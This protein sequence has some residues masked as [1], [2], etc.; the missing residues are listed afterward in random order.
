VAFVHQLMD[1]PAGHA[2]WSNVAIPNGLNIVMNELVA[3]VGLFLRLIS[4][5][6]LV[7]SEHY[8]RLLAKI[9]ATT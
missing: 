7:F 5:N 3:A 1:Q 9:R 2:S 4:Y 8:D 6:R